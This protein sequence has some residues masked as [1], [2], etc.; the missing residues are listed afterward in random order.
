MVDTRKAYIGGATVTAVIAVLQLKPGMIFPSQR[1]TALMR[2]GLT[3][4]QKLKLVKPSRKMTEEVVT[5]LVGEHALPI[6]DFLRGKT[7]ISEFIVAEEL[8]MEINETRNILYKLFEHNIVTFIRKKDRIKGWYICYW[9]LNEIMVPQ[10]KEKM[11]DQKLEKMEERLSKEE[12]HTFY[13]CSNAC[14]RMD[15]D[16]AMEFQFKCPECGSLMHQQDNTRT[17]E[18]LKDRIKELRKTK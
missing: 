16:T 15:F 2:G 9:D 17:I 7:R 4:N 13:L 1:E 3:M 12:A 5:E 14:N 10:I 8:D 18:F 11:D 6:I